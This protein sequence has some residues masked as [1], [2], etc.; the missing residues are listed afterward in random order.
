MTTDAALDARHD[1]ATELLVPLARG[2]HAYGMP[3]HR[4]EEALG[5]VAAAL[6]IRAQFLATP[7]S[8]QAAIGSESRHRAVLVRVEPGETNLEKL[9]LL[10]EVMDALVAGTLDARV[11]TERVLRIEGAGMRYAATATVAAYAGTTATAGVF[12]GGGWREVVAGGA[13]GVL[14]G[15]IAVWAVRRPRAA[16]AY[17]AI[18]AFVATAVA[19]LL[20]PALSPMAPFLASL[21][22]M[23]V[24]VPG[25]T[26]TVAVNELANRHLVSGTARFT[27]ALIVFLQMGIGVAVGNLVVA[28]APVAPSPPATVPLG[29][30]W[31]ALA[32]PL[33]A[34]AMTVL[35]RARPVDYPAIAVSAALAYL[36][37]RYGG[38]W[39]GAE[40]GAATAAWSL[41]A[42]SNLLARVR[43]RPSAITLVPGLVMLVPGSVGFR[44]LEALLRDDVV[45][46]IATG[47][48]MVLIA[49]SIVTGLFLANL[50]VRPRPFS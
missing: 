38:A 35:F 28:H 15:V 21:A 41:G 18:A 31:L 40:I 3:S 9:T 1:E 4:L 25:L 6:G 42:F 12:F 46:G 33:A 39:L 26:L 17:P 37:A 22:G 19:T 50:T 7:T 10:T 47:F 23:I 16:L 36:V 48:D 45:A 24:L 29:P 49:G 32:L 5:S 2:L 27:G 8:I 13:I 14:L 44:S 11:A 43:R 20:A 30:A 34:I